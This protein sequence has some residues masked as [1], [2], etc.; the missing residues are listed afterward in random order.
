MPDTIDLIGLL[1]AR[2]AEIL[3]RWTERIRVEHADKALTRGE[4]TDHLPIFFNQ[5]LTALSGVEVAGTP[6]GAEAALSASIAHGT[7]RLRVG[8]DLSEV[9]REYETLT[10]CILDEVQGLGG[11]TSIDSFRK[12]QRVVNAGRAQAVAAY[13]RRRDEDLARAHSQHVAFIA[14]ELRNPLMTASMALA[15]LRKTA[16][17][18][19]EGAFSRLG[20]SLVALREL[21]DEVLVADRLQGHVQLQPEPLDLRT[22][23]EEAISDARL[24]AEQR[25][26]A[27]LLDAPAPL[28]FCGDQ[29]LLRSAINNI[30]GN[31][32]KFT[33]EGESVTLRGS[34][35]GRSLMIAVEDRCGGLAE[36]NPQELFEPFVQGKSSRTGFGLG[37]AIV[38]QALE[39]HG[40]RV[41]IQNL[42]GKGCIFSLELPL[43]RTPPESVTA[44]KG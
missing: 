39:A 32:I 25:R 18:E 27:L 26:I 9:I 19:D 14:H 40:G 12:V 4:L 38:K 7:Q 5:V 44:I 42:P 10:E 21:I 41:T 20:R 24:S 8:F 22:L 29:R 23:L 17:P 37:L 30:L 35:C 36:T 43:E 2:R 33:H 3:Q 1:E 31:A 15:V 11:S 16:R 34:R 6:T 13:V 28:P